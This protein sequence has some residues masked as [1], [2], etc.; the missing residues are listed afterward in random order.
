MIRGK[1]FLSGKWKQM[2]EKLIMFCLKMPYSCKLRKTTNI[3]AKTNKGK[4]KA[5]PVQAWTGPEG[6]RRF[7]LPDF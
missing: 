6:S 4:G 5:M 2:Q 1:V 3:Y 7:R